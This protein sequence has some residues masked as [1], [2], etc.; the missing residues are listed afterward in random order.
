MSFEGWAILEVMGHRRLAGH[1][2]EVTIA[3]AQMLRIDIP[4]PTEAD[5]VKA[6]QFYPGSS[7]FCL[8]PTTEETTR[9][10]ANPPKWEPTP[11]Q[12]GSGADGGEDEL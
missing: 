2:S 12:L 11:F 10:E 6:T 5:P 9:R 8:T 3:G 4:G 1:V 7:V